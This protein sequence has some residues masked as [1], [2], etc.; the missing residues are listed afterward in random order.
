M[1]HKFYMIYAPTY[2]NKK[3]HTG[4]T[5]TTIGTSKRSM[6][7]SFIKFALGIRHQLR[8]VLC[9]WDAALGEIDILWGQIAI[10]IWPAAQAL[11]R[12]ETR[13]QAKATGV[14]HNCC[15]RKKDIIRN[16]FETVGGLLE[17]PVGSRWFPPACF[18]ALHHW[19]VAPAPTLNKTETLKTGLVTD[20]EWQHKSEL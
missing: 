10:S 19:R 3:T 12:D 1:S 16:G 17:W 14:K 8:C 5:W 18:T 7:K 6:N 13:R 2:M 4:S 20:G 9:F 11:R 15:C